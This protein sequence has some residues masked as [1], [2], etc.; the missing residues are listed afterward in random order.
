MDNKYKM[1]QFKAKITIITAVDV[2]DQT[3]GQFG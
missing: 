3:P 2:K 1:L